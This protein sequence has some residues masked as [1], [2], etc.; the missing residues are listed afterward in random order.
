MHYKRD[1]MKVIV[2]KYPGGPEVLKMSTRPVPKPLKREVLIRVAAAGINGADLRER[3]GN[4][5]VPQHAPDVMGLEVSGEVVEI[6]VECKRFKVGD[7]VCALIVGGGY[8]EYAIAPEEQCMTIPE[9]VTLLE[10]AGIPE[11]FCTVWT[12]MIDQCKLKAGERVLIQGGTSGIGHAAISIAKAFGAI[13]YATARSEEKC[14]AI[15]RFGADFAINYMTEDFLDICKK[16]S[17]Q[18]GVDLILDIIGGN[19]LPREIELLAKNGRL[20]ILNLRGGKKAKVDFSHVH[21]KHLTITGA[22]LRPRQIKEK[23][24]ICDSLE[25]YIWPLF[26]SRQILP[27]IHGIY[28]FSQ[29]AEAHKVMEASKHI[30]KLLLVPDHNF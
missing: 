17:N 21:S 7:E 30:G 11:V 3:Q 2:T 19:Y 22:R 10:A 20:M 5:P 27:E 13:V 8:A 12:S 24:S 9:N 6:G 16:T 28:S 23:S 26:A 29:V 15:K 18:Y 4:Y 1:S 25:E 14:A